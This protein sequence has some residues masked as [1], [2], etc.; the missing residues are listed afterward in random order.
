MAN[1]RLNATVQIGSVLERSVKKNIGILRS[2]LEGVGNEIKTITDRQKEMSKQRK[3][4]EAQGRSVADLDQEYE[5]L[6]RQLDTLRR[7]QAAW[8]RAAQASA[9]VGQDFRRMTGDLT[10]VARNAGVAIGL[11]GT[12]I[13]TLA[14]STAALGDD[15]AKTADKLGIGI[16]AFQ[17]LRYAAERSGVPIATFDSSMGAF[18]KRLGEAKDGTG[19]AADAIKELGLNV[20]D[21]IEMKP[22]DALLEIAEKFKDVKN[23][24]ERAALSADLF[25]RAGM[26]MIIMLRDGRAGLEDLMQA[27]SDTGY[28]L[29]EKTARGAEV[30]QDRLLDAQLTVKGLK[31]VIGAEFIP[32][33]QRAMETFT[34]WA[35]TNREDIKSFAEQAVLSLERVIPIVGSLAS[36]LSKIAVTVGSVVSKV[37]DMVGGWE[38]FGMVLG[39]LMASKAIVSV[40][41]FGLSVVRLGT[42]LWA[43]GP[44]LPIVAAGI[45]AIG[46]ALL[47]NPV[48]IAIAAIAGG[49]L[50]IYKN[51]ESIGPWFSKQMDGLKRFFSGLSGPIEPIKQAWQ[52]LRETLGTVI[53][54]IGSSFDRVMEKIRP[55]VDALKWVSGKAGSALS[56]VGIGGNDGPSLGSAENPFPPGHPM[57]RPQMRAVGGSFRAGGL[58]VGEGGPELMYPSQSGFIANNRATERIASLAADA[59]AN[60]KAAFGGMNGGSGSVTNHIQINAAGLSA[61]SILDELERRLRD[62]NSGSLYDGARG[63]G[64]YG[65]AV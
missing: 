28:V 25:S 22:E 59:R 17:Q 23:P 65:G 37:A 49:A 30:F 18:V 9:R 48:G 34:T 36:G 54:W 31:N 52:S 62:A 20:S 2:G 12:A 46:L 29:T 51:W 55:V 14:S 7:K 26:G 10:R 53:N 3:V 11:V 1:Q 45:K 27:G 56:A 33:V 47:A 38:N 15:V 60:I 61:Q 16:E 40:A 21:L 44:A 50:L 24:A 41:R 6:G 5:Q 19:P 64:Q 32:V 42:A 58:V 35:K 13:F 8:T 4:L 39:T 43:L 57:H 63:Y